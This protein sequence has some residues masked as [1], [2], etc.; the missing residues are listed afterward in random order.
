MAEHRFFQTFMTVGASMM[1]VGGSLVLLTSTAPFTS[2]PEA[3][4]PSTPDSAR[5]SVATLDLNRPSPPVEPTVDRGDTVAPS[6]PEAA[7]TDEAAVTELPA[8]DDNSVASLGGPAAPEAIE[9][10]QADTAE[11][12]AATD[13]V[14]VPEPAATPEPDGAITDTASAEAEPA[15]TLETDGTT[16]D[17]SAEPATT[18]EPDVAVAPVAPTVDAQT[19]AAPAE[20]VAVAEE[21]A[22]AASDQIG[23]ILTALPPRTIA[24][25]SSGAATGKVAELLAA[26]PPAPTPKDANPDVAVVTPAPPLPRHKPEEE[27]QAETVAALPGPQEKPAKTAKPA[28]PA[29]A[30][31]QTI[32]RREATEPHAKSK[33]QPMG[34]APADTP[35]IAPVPTARPTSA[36]YSSKVWSALARHK[37]RAGQSGSALV[38]FA[39]GE[40]GGLRGLRIG[41]SSGNARIDQLAL[42]TVRGAAPF[43]PPPSGTA[44]YSIRIDFH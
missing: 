33:W 26:T 44:S 17:A 29:A 11:G 16:T 2:P 37:P 21:K 31:E 32:A 10:G 36:A 4:E 12:M 8:A 6:E 27:P 9:A 38:M 35:A 1:L 14:A 34:L 42:A 43:P 5:V 18:P 24:S 30:P 40:N 3:T 22:N 28:A 23:E 41:R 13:E 7:V 25:D 15:A 39:I 20:P 19:N